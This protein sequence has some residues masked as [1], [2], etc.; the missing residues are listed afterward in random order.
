[1]ANN[2]LLKYENRIFMSLCRSAH[3]SV[4]SSN[5]VLPTTTLASGSTTGTSLAST[6]DGNTGVGEISAGTQDNIDNISSSSSSMQQQQQNTATTSTTPI[7]PSLLSESNVLSLPS[8]VVIETLLKTLKVERD[9]ILRI[10]LLLFL[11]ENSTLL[12]EEDSKRFERVFS[13]LQSLVNSQIDS[14][15]VKSQVLSTMTTILVCESI[16]KTHPRLVETFIDL[17]LDIINKVNNSP[18]RLL[19]GAA[20]LCLLE[21]ELTYPCSTPSTPSNQGSLNYRNRSL[22]R[23]PSS[24]SL[25]LP[26]IFTDAPSH[27]A[28]FSIPHNVKYAP[29]NAP[30][31]TNTVVSSSSGTPP[32]TIKLSEPLSKELLKFISVVVDQ[33]PHLNQWGLISIIQQLIPLVDIAAIPSTIFKHPHLYKLLFTKNPLQFHLLLYLAIQFPDIYTPV[34]LELFFSRLL[35]SEHPISIYK[36]YTQ[37]YPNSFDSLSLKEV[38][39]YAMVKCI[40][41]FESNNSTLVQPPSIIG[42]MNGIPERRIRIN[43]FLSL[44]K[45]IV[46]LKPQKFLHYLPLVERIVLEDQINPTILFKP[47]RQILATVITYFAN[48]EI[49]DRA[50]FYDRLLTHLP[51]DKIKA[52]LVTQGATTDDPAMRGIGMPSL[53][54]MHII[55]SLN[56][57]VSIAPI[58]GKSIAH[59]YTIDSANLPEV[60]SSPITLYRALVG[61]GSRLAAKIQVPYRIRY[62]PGITPVNFPVKVYALLIQFRQSAPLYA[63]INPIRIPYLCHTDREEK[64]LEFPYCFDVDLT[65]HPLHPIP[66]TFTVKMVFNDDEGKTCKAGGSVITL[67]FQDLFMQVPIPPKASGPQ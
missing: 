43:L 33:S 19:R 50:T 3:H 12:L 7:I 25:V 32:P 55:K 15:P 45:V 59:L 40:V 57:F 5:A 36:Y 48:V 29:M 26:S 52:M 28:S 61:D 60:S 58:K 65:F 62:R 6:G 46:A 37:F 44:S 51:D 13:I 20:C 27:S 11:Q 66:T 31:R 14:Y 47:L 4:S 1:M 34:E 24:S 49:R 41:N 22:S 16:I 8:T 56:N 63:P 53:A 17:L 38:K 64:A 54:T 42:L 30:P 35:K 9:D 10:N 2:I 18:D 67:Q 21:L 39:L 23:M